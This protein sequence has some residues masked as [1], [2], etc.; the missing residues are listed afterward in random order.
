MNRFPIHFLGVLALGLSLIAC[1]NTPSAAEQATQ[2]AAYERLVSL[3]G[4]VT[5]LLYELEQGDK[6][7][8]VDVTSTYPVEQLTE[9]PK[10][11]HVRQLN[12]E[13][14]LSLQPDL[15]LAER[16]DEAS[17][18][19]QQLEAA[20]VEV[21]WLDGSFTLDKPLAQA[22]QISEKLGLNEELESLRKTY[23]AD[24]AKLQQ[25]RQAMEETPKVLFI[26][27]RGKGSLMV[28]GKNT[29]ASAMIELAGG[30]NAVQSFE[31]FRALS[32]EGLIEA[33]PEVLLLFDSGLQSLGGVE[34][35]L[36]IPGLAQTPAGQQGHI[37]GMDG[38]YLLGFTPRAARA[39]ADLSGRLQ[40]LP[41][42]YTLN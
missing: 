33:Q 21:L 29:A 10:L 11:G 23:K 25:A 9:L 24:K 30:Q 4:S 6:I 41:D 16:T 34:G 2:E 26:Y 27:A 15:V 37:I 13:A 31:G 32:A 18:A 8:G 38:L 39:A 40:A 35:L 17:A 42:A 36:Q 12:V 19:L 1:Q 28:A 3:S 5:E 20:G 14:L 7:V 22:E